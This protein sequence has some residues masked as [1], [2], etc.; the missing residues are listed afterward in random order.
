MH[1]RVIKPRLYNANDA[2][3]RI[4]PFGHDVANFRFFSRHSLI[5][6]IRVKKSGLLEGHAYGFWS[7]MIHDTLVLLLKVKPYIPWKEKFFEHDRLT[8]CSANYTY[9]AI[10][11]SY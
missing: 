1:C 8:E 4:Y 6:K 7:Q 5:C 10:N 9:Y 3:K 2:K 11:C